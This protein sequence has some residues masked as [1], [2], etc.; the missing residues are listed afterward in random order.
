M[1]S[2][3]I[4]AGFLPAADAELRSG[5]YFISLDCFLPSC[6]VIETSLSLSREEINS[7]LDWLYT[8][9][10]CTYP[11]TQGGNTSKVA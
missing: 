11:V 9:D 6:Y 8:N 2:A 1:I 3:A 7:E 4:M 10:V 5:A